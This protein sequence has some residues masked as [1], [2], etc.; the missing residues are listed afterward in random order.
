MV[1][2]TRRAPTGRRYWRTVS[3]ASLGG[4]MLGWL[5]LTSAWCVQSQFVLSVSA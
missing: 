1:I 4:L 2:V 5:A 3:V